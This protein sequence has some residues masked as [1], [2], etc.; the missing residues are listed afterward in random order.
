MARKY[1]KVKTLLCGILLF[2]IGAFWVGSIFAQDFITH[3]DIK[4]AGSFI[5]LAIG[6]GLIL[7]SASYKLDAKGDKDE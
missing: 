6:E 7:E 1:Y 4:I 2:G 3:R 5:V